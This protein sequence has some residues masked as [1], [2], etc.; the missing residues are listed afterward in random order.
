MLVASFE[1]WTSSLIMPHLTT[2]AFYLCLQCWDFTFLLFST[3]Y[4]ITDLY[5]SIVK[6][7]DRGL[8]LVLSLKHDNCL[9][10]GSSLNHLI[11]S[12]IAQFL[13]WSS[14]HIR[15]HCLWPLSC[16][17]FRIFCV[18]VN[19]HNSNSIIL[20]DFL[21]AYLSFYLTFSV[22]FVPIS[23]SSFRI[24]CVLVNFC[25]SNFIILSNFLFAYLSFYLTFLV[26]FVPKLCFRM[27]S[28]TSI[29]NCLNPSF[30][31]WETNKS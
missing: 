21:F 14:R 18:L 16:S 28:F 29:W 4:M 6:W 31:G 13:W 23:C 15:H 7:M 3:K 30:V 11:L 19:F 24:F 2:N 5:K 27:S 1:T 26:F 9:C 12:R 10:L 17:Y 8:L 20:S 22:F 25:N